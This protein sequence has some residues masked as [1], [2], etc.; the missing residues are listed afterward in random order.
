LYCG[1][2][3][4]SE[5][6]RD[7]LV[8]M[9]KNEHYWDKERITLKSLNFEAVADGISGVELFQR[10]EIATTSLSSEELSSSFVVNLA[11]GS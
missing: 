6:D 7:K 11:G 3:Y 4:I 10:G 5:W 2:Y 8:V 1:G 9:T